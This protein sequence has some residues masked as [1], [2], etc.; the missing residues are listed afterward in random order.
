[1]INV[2]KGKSPKPVDTATA[3]VEGFRKKCEDLNVDPRR[4]IEVVDVLELNL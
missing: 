3:Y 1:M 4:V 2:L